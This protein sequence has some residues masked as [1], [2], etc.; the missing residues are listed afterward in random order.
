M[1]RQKCGRTV[2][3]GVFLIPVISVLVVLAR[4]HA[5]RWEWEIF[6]SGGD[7]IPDEA[8][9]RQHGE[10]FHDEKKSVDVVGDA[11]IVSPSS[12]VAST[13]TAT[14]TEDP[15]VKARALEDRKAGLAELR[16]S[17]TFFSHDFFASKTL[18]KKALFP[19]LKPRT[20]DLSE[21]C[22][23]PTLVSMWARTYRNAIRKIY[24]DDGELWKGRMERREQLNE[25]RHIYSYKSQA[26]DEDWKHYY[27]TL[28]LEYTEQVNS[29]SS[30]I[31]LPTAS[32]D[33]A[34]LQ[35]FENRATLKD[36]LIRMANTAGYLAELLIEGAENKPWNRLQYSADPERS[37]TKT[38]FGYFRK[39]SSST[40]IPLLRYEDA[41]KDIQELQAE[42]TPSGKADTHS[43]P[44]E[45]QLQL[46]S[47]PALSDVH[48]KVTAEN[49]RKVG[50]A[51]LRPSLT[52]FSDAFFSKENLRKLSL[53]PDLTSNTDDPSGKCWFPTLV[54][55]WA[56]T[57]RG[58]IRKIYP[59][60]PNRT[61]IDDPTRRRELSELRADLIWVS[62]ATDEDRKLYYETSFLEYTEKV[63][64][65]VKQLPAE[66]DQQVD[67]TTL[68]GLRSQFTSI[69]NDAGY[70]VSLEMEGEEP[71]YTDMIP[72]FRLY[73][74][75][76]Q[77][78]QNGLKAFCPWS[79][80]TE[81]THREA[82]A[83]QLERLLPGHA[84]RNS[85]SKVETLEQRVKVDISTLLATVAEQ[86]QKL[87]SFCDF[88][89]KT[90]GSGTALDELVG[91]GR[92]RSQGDW[93][94]DDFCPE[95]ETRG[96]AAGNAV[97]KRQAPRSWRM[98]CI[99]KICAKYLQRGDALEEG[100]KSAKNH[101][102]KSTSLPQG[103]GA[104]RG[105]AA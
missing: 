23:F 18:R 71:S 41:E 87:K 97:S 91:Y 45:R 4:D 101:I 80:T 89:S 22:R 64:L 72:L 53:F 58:A 21:K 76:T 51:E 39:E 82:A 95:E 8:E 59:D 25:W 96:S 5:H 84:T 78:I 11:P 67:E 33:D 85:H 47:T 94:D 69:A 3:I 35:L 100:L 83:D 42:C 40:T 81:D 48:E 65:A 54:A 88:A 92:G 55:M 99:A 26:N 2:T 90:F 14:T 86:D 12:F 44:A 19:D 7:V 103:A 34:A 102:E 79:G 16:P 32:T 28:F 77:D 15:E 98:W 56:K 46:L 68:E 105:G 43:T 60:D 70:L 24:P 10:E 61:I 31:E 75:A 66:L 38:V 37:S 13:E 93:L 1:D 17:L 50:L 27:E 49:T 74:S 57:L 62:K 104:G 30:K 9:T 63:H 6:P 36:D 52:F 29:A 20:E 73:E